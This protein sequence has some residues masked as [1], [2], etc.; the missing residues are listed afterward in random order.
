MVDFAGWLMP[1]QYSSI[2]QEHQATRRAV[3]LFDV[4]HMGRLKFSGS[5]ACDFL[6]RLVTRDVKSL[7]RGQVRY[8]LV[9][10][11]D[12]GV[13][14]DVLVYHLAEH[15]YGESYYQLVV[16]A[17]N[18]PKILDW[19]EQQEPDR[20]S[21]TIQDRTL[22]TAML[23]V[24]GPQAIHSVRPLS[25]VD[26]AALLYFSAI[27]AKLG[28]VPGILGRTGYTG[29]DG[30]ELI[31]PADAAV[32]IWKSLIDR[33]AQP[34][35]LGCRDTLRL[36][37][38]MPLYGHELNDGVNPYQAGLGFAVNLDGRLFPGRDALAKIRSDPNQPKRVGLELSG[39]RVPREHCGVLAG[40]EPAGIVTSGT[41]SP[42]RE[43]PI[44]MAYVNAKFAKPDTELMV[45]IR[46]KREPA[47]VVKLPFYKRAK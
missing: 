22:E 33:G 18:R 36:E 35:G 12:G 16:N 13:L 23:A 32:D 30:W 7:A 40:D 10:N 14:D 42:T 37:A 27:E 21:V 3:G 19:I 29:E 8:A 39:K 5:G 11:H 25:S 47:R 34:A 24:Q 41:F 4:S 17:G 9:T 43:R 20:D 6:D 1:V 45:D 2:V 46:G 28:G 38:A 31:V 26:P 15:A 44:A